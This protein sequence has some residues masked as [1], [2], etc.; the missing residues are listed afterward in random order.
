MHFPDISPFPP[1]IPP[2]HAAPF[3]T[4]VFTIPDPGTGMSA[5]IG[6]FLDP[7]QAGPSAQPDNEAV[8]SDETVITPALT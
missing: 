5:D 4:D 2:P 1:P 8:A 7:L 3:P 6:N